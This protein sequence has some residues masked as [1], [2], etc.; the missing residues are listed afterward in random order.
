M[1]PSI[2]SYMVSLYRTRCVYNKLKTKIVQCKSRDTTLVV[3]LIESCRKPTVK[4]LHAI[5][6]L[7]VNGAL[8]TGSE[9]N[10]TAVQDGH[11]WLEF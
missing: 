2:S 10:T 4:T 11:D 6:L 1:R 7:R 5:K 9:V 3:S 8:N